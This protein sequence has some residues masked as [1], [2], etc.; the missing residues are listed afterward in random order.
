M[1]FQTSDGVKR[2]RIVEHPPGRHNERYWYVLEVVDGSF[3]ARTRLRHAFAERRR[4]PHG[5]LVSEADPVERQAAIA[6]LTAWAQRN[7]WTIAN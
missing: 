3:P 4:E 2:A 7:G 6:K 5:T 1:T